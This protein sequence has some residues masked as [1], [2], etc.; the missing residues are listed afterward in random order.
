MTSV[1]DE[2]WREHQNT[3]WNLMFDELRKFKDS[4]GHCSVP[5]SYSDN[6]KLGKWVNNQRV[7]RSKISK[8]RAS[9][10]DSIGFTWEAEPEVRWEIMFEELRKFKDGAGHCNVPFKFSDNPELGTWVRRQRGQ[11]LKTS[12]ER[13]SKLD[14]IGF[15]WGTKLD[16]RLEIMFEELR[17]FKDREAHCN[18]PHSFYDN[19][20][21]GKWVKKST[22]T[23]ITDSKGKIFQT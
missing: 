7:R 4:E 15:T 3:A 22:R 16:A 18:V 13:A 20:G 5:Q 14:S 21:L 11:R 9:K 12:K 19:P 8:E 2:G 23:E 17:Q 1:V 10:L 6:P